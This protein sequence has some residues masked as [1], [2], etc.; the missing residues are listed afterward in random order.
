MKV[1]SE[2]IPCVLRQMLRVARIASEGDEWLERRILN[3]V[4]GY[5]IDLG[6]DLTPAEL[7]YL[8]HR[9]VNQFLK[10]SDPFRQERRES[11]QTA[12][13]LEP[14]MR[15]WIEKEKDKL[16]GAALLA[17]A[18][19]T[20]D[21]LLERRRNLEIL[22][23]RALTDGFAH[24]DYESLLEDLKKAKRILYI[25][26]SAG[27][28]VGDKLFLEQLEGKEITLVARQ[29]PIV[30]DATF[31]DVK[32]A[33]LSYPVVDPEV[34]SRGVPLEQ[35]T[36]RFREIFEAADLI[37]AKGQANYETLRTTGRECYY[38]LRAKCEYMA[39]QLGVKPRGLVLLKE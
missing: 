22:L 9:W 7:T 25:L 23:Q 5:L 26:S 13:A 21:D 36:K 3:E 20:Y 16:L 1:S 35:A 12:L 15:E 18:L 10:L 4:M 11:V 32:L 19:N 31:E 6:A 37:I 24:S 8:C 2:C 38:L 14:K 30:L 17:T 33:G 27:E 29:D 34:E 39:G 28:L